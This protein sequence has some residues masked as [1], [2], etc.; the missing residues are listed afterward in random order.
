ML[1][2]ETR[3]SNLKPQICRFQKTSQESAFPTLSL[4]LN[5]PMPA[6]KSSQMA[7]TKM[8]KKNPQSKKNV[9]KNFNNSQFIIIRLYYINYGKKRKGFQNK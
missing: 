1:N 5:I 4:K 6:L 7:L 8:K 2:F 3:T 9:Q